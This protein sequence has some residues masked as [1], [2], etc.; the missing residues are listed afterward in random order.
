MYILDYYIFI[1]HSFLH[2]VRKLNNNDYEG[3]TKSFVSLMLFTINMLFFSVVY[4]MAIFAGLLHFHRV[5]I[6]VFAIFMAM[7]SFY[8]VFTRYKV[9]YYAVIA[10]LQ[11]LYKYSTARICITF[12]LSWFIPVFSFW[13]GLILIRKLIY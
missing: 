12:I 7:L 1:T 11:K 2:V 6:F 9:S 3:R 8:I 4:G 10:S 5:G 13:A